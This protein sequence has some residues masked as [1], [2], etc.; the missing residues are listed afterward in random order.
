MN[1]LN[2]YLKDGITEEEL[3]FT[4]N[5][6]G[7]KDALKYETTGQKASFMKYIIENNFDDQLVNKQL[8]ILNQLTKA[9][10]DQ[11]STS[12]I[13][14][15]QMYIIVVGD[16]ATVLDPLKKLGYPVIEMDINEMGK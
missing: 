4:K 12:Y 16:R 14:P 8:G 9:D 3:T 11:I 2:S 15:T 5:S 1:D 13:H 10:V 6:I 7:Q